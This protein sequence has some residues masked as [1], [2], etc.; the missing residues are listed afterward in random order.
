M[1]RMSMA[2]FFEFAGL[3]VIRSFLPKQGL[4]LMTPFISP[5]KDELA[6][7]TFVFDQHWLWERSVD[8]LQDSHR[9]Q[10]HVETYIK[11]NSR[12]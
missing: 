9:Q 7:I 5:L 8:C 12:I 6:S 10:L 3:G 2:F 11:H 1:C 4:L